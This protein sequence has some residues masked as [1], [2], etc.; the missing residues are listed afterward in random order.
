MQVIVQGLAS[1]YRRHNEQIEEVTGEKIH[2]IYIVGGGRNNRYLNQCT[3]DATGCRVIAGH[4][5][6]TAMG[7]LLIQLWAAGEVASMEEI[8]AIAG[9]NVTEEIYVPKCNKEV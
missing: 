9:K 7:N 5:E 2:T 6:A 1:E 3:A 8:P 4:P